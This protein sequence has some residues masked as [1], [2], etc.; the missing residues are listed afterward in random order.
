MAARRPAGA[1]ADQTRVINDADIHLSPSHAWALNLRMAFKAEIQ[2]ALDQQ[3]GVDAPVW[4]VAGRASLAHGRVL[5]DKG[6]GLLPMALG[7]RFIPAC[8]RQ[9]TGRFEDVVAMGIVTLRAVHLFLQ[10]RVVLGEVKFRLFLAMAFE[11]GGGVFARIDDEFASP[12]TAR[13]MQA[14]G[15]VA[16]FAARLPERA[17]VFELD[18]GV[19]AGRKDTG[20][21]FMALDTTLV[22]DERRAWDGGWRKALSRGGRT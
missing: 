18:S 13:H 5:K 8:H 15:S 10:D 4:V 16:R 2:V 7:A 3:F 9:A 11:T 17:D 12:A 14:R 21:A 19:G 1:H 6:P 22:A 20:N